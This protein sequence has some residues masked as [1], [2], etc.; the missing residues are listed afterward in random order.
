M[1][2]VLLCLAGFQPTLAKEKPGP[3]EPLLEADDLAYDGQT[4]IIT[5]TGHVEVAMGDQIM[6][7]DKIVYNKNTDV[8]RASGHIAMTQTSGEVLYAEDVEI[9]SDL[10]QAFLN[11]VGIIFPDNSRL[12]AKDAQRYEGRYLVADRGVYTA[13][14]LCAENPKDP[15]LWQIKGERV[16]HDS[17]AKEVIYRDATIEFDG[18]PVFFTP[19]FSHPDSTVARQQGF[20]APMAGTSKALGFWTSVPYYFDIDTYTDLVVMPTFSD[21][22]KAQMAADWRYRFANGSM[23]WRGS[24]TQADFT[25]TEGIDKG[26]R[27]RGDL[28][29]TARFDLTDTWRA[30]TDVAL[31][32][33]KSYLARY[34][35]S[36]EDLLVNRAYA[37]N[38]DGRNYAVGNMYYFQ[39]L[40][41]TQTQSEPFVA[42]EL[43][44]SAYGEPNETLGG[45]W[46]FDSGMLVTTRDQNTATADKGPNT[47]RLSLETGWERQFVSSTGFLTEVSMETRADGYWAD[48]MPTTTDSDGTTF[49]N[50]QRTRTFAQGDVTM[51]YPFGRQGEGYQQILEPISVLSVAPR[52]KQES[53]YPNEDSLDVTYDETNLFST[54]RFTGIDR[55]EGGTRIAYGARNTITTNGGGR[56][57]MLGGQIYRT[58][59]DTD[60]P[61]ESGL[62]DQFSDYVGRVDVSPSKYFDATYGFRLS[63]N[64]FDFTRQLA[65]VSAGPA[66]FRPSVRYLLTQETE[67]TTNTVEPLEEG[68]IGFSS[69]FAKYWSLTAAHTQAFQPDP[70]ARSTSFGVTYKDECFESSIT[71]EHNN[72]SRTDIESGTSVMFRLFLKNIGGW[73]SQQSQQQHQDKL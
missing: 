17:E 23:R 58:R 14:N 70:G 39:D 26:Q 59:D 42:P 61:D 8:V 30:G 19:Y 27:W 69:A 9:T 16:T 52:I 15:P 54:N 56:V 32:S 5:A 41:P 25:N 1:V 7:A 63:K 29:G 71:A 65:T 57:E 53:L 40:R 37:E 45:R 10:K 13:C 67:A 34:K 49:T 73:G 4:G 51:R 60:F 72:T 3:K 44:Y 35:I 31:S 55:L 12:V 46:S 18:V 47:R 43:R 38:F 33:D 64:D 6:R 62:R 68:S 36:S 11:R 48:D 66:I 22:D 28:F 2:V 50:V 21:E 20:L 24:F